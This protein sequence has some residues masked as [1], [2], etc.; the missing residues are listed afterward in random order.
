MKKL[1]LAAFIAVSACST[2]TPPTSYS[3]R[4]ANHDGDAWQISVQRK[5]GKAANTMTTIINGTTISTLKLT[6]LSTSNNASGQYQDKTVRTEC[7][8]ALQILCS[9]R[10]DGERAATITF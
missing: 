6:T 5:Q 8:D 10:V 4:P 3:Y 7:T 9:V 2:V 1:I